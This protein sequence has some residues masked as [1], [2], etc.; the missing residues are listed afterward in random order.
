[1]EKA[2]FVYVMTNELLRDDIV[3]IGLTQTSCAER[4][5]SVASDYRLPGA[6][7]VA[8]SATVTD[9]KAAEAAVHKALEAH[10]I[11]WEL[12]R[13]TVAEAKA[14]IEEAARP[15][16]LDAA[17]AEADGWLVGS[18][19]VLPDRQAKASSAAKKA[20]RTMRRSAGAKQAWTTRRAKSG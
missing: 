20:H 11:D 16:H 4:M 7:K 10:R 9:A 3:K 18:T 14:A 1:M 17:K 5:R 8:F 12:F 13:V 15:F 6:W 2:G 19:F